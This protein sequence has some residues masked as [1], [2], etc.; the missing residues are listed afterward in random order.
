MA[1]GASA[2]RDRP[3][4]GYRGLVEATARVLGSGADQ[5]RATFLAR[6]LHALAEL[7]PTLGPRAL[8]HAE[9]AP[10]DYAALLYAV[11][12]PE[13]LDAWRRQD[14]L[15]EARRRGL[16]ARERLLAAEGGVMTAEEVAGLLRLSRQAVDKRRRAG[17]LLALDTGRRGYLYPAWQFGPR[18]VLPGLEAVLG[19]FDGVDPWSQAAW[20]L[21][22]DARLDD[23]TPLE[24]L[25]RGEAEAVR[26]AA[27]AYGGT[28]RSAPGGRRGRRRPAPA[29]G[30]GPHRSSAVGV[31]RPA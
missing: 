23:D 12:D 1:T 24:A 11:Q 7:A 14:P 27:A 6:A 29:R 25:R 16:A 3:G 2:R 31:G 26:R 28:G 20:F 4:A 22:G 10:S 17:R 30:A 9:R 21:S 13:T 8:A 18:G 19:A 5:A 15:A